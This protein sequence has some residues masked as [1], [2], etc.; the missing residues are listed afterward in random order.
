MNIECWKF[1]KVLVKKT[2]IIKIKKENKNKIKQKN[3]KIKVTK[4]IRNKKLTKNY[5]NYFQKVYQ[6]KTKINLLIEKN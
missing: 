2:K 3:K 4:K 1:Q 6:K 5:V